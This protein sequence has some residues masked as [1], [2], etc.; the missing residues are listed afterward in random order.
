MINILNEKEYMKKN[1]ITKEELEKMTVKNVEVSDEMEVGSILSDLFFEHCNNDIEEVAEIL[2]YVEIE[3]ILKDCNTG[4]LKESCS[5]IEYYLLKHN[6]IYKNE[7]E[8]RIFLV[9]FD[10]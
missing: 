8:T 10:K 6:L 5:F 2:I 7:D 9:S 4:F 1:N 3:D